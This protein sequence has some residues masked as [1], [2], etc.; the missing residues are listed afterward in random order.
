MGSF[1]KL[2]QHFMNNNNWI[3][4][5]LLIVVIFELQK[6][7][8]CSCAATGGNCGAPGSMTTTANVPGW[9]EN[10]GANAQ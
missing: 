9:I 7:A 8:D 2:H 10:L 5:G 6:S 1:Q 3:T 4:W